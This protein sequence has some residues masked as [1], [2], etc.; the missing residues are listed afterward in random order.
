MCGITGFNWKNE[1]LLHLMNKAILHR[2]PHGEG[3]FAEDNISLGLRKCA[4]YNV[5]ENIH[6]P[7]FTGYRDLTLVFNGIIYNFLELRDEL[8][9]K[10]HHFRSR[11]DAEVI[12]HCYQEYG[13]DCVRHFNGMWAFCI[14][15]KTKKT[16]F[17][18]RDR[19]GIKPLYYHYD[20]DKF[21]FASEIKALLEHDIP[22]KENRA[23]IFDYLY[24]NLTDHTEETFFEGIKRLMPGHNLVFDLTN[25][26]IQISKYYDIRTK[27][28]ECN[29]DY[30]IIKELFTDSV[31]R[32]LVTN[33]SVGSCL[34]GGIDSSSVVVTMKKVAPDMD[35]KTFSMNFPG[36]N[37]DESIYQ[38][39]VNTKV[40]A[41]NYS[42]TP[43][44]S[45][46]L[47]DMKDLFM[48]QEEPFSGTSVYGQY[49]VMKLAR[50]NG[51]VV[52]LD[53]QGAD[54]VLAGSAYFTGYYYYELMKEG[55]IIDLFRETIRSCQQSSCLSSLMYLFLRI[56]PED[57]KKT[58]YKRHKA[59]YL[60]RSFIKENE[61]RK[62]VRWHLS[63]LD[64]AVCGSVSTYALPHLL[65]FLDKNSMRFSIE[66]R[67]PFLDHKLVEYLVSLPPKQ[68][69]N[70][71]V[72]KYAFRK[73]MEEELPEKILA[74]RD[75]IGFAVPEKSWLKEEAVKGVINNIIDSE[76][77]KL[78]DFWE[79]DKVEREFERLQSGESQ[80]IFVGTDI[81]RCISVELWMRI[82]IDGQDFATSREQCIPKKLVPV[83]MA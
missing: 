20:N 53:G 9:S 59:P 8:I 51:I 24:Y 26:E 70:G 76:S 54:Q 40:N 56:V 38:Q 61:H 4:I 28:T 30:G 1:R 23:I 47:E 27:A 58:L 44:S 55:N 39:E 25:N 15:D 36:K 64:E 50:D 46:L 75:K 14:Y 81:W 43:E 3:T 49:R 16:L 19:F 21:I 34:S 60:S 37:I 45:D 5:S 48:T 31:K 10:G 35:I 32:S 12:L 42:V 78:R 22:R 71:G 67:V 62:D 29:T 13:A 82:F 52:L 83:Q 68:R 6:Q 69:I 73:A 79:W 33:A 11:T 72:T 7:M 18:S 74:R 77:F 17:L 41:M 63:S 66:S 2:G 80:S 65:R 57:I